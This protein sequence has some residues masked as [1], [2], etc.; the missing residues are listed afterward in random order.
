MSSSDKNSGLKI[1]SLSQSNLQG[2]YYGSNGGIVFQSM[3]NNSYGYLAV[4]STTGESLV[5]ILH[6][7]ET[8]MTMMGVNDTQFLFMRNPPGSPERSLVM[9]P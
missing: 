8:T 1:I 7:I 2:A 9:H 3:I 5:F 6:P 4:S